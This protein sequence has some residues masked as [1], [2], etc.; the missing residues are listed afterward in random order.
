MHDD[1]RDNTWS[2]SRGTV[3]DLVQIAGRESLDYTGFDAVTLCTPSG[4]HPEQGVLAAQAGF[5]VVT[6]KPMGIALEPVD[7]MIRACDE[8]GVR[9]FTVL[10]NRLNP[11]VAL[12]LLTIGIYGLFVEFTS[13]GFGVPGVAGAIALLLGLYALHLLPV[14]WVGVGLLLFGAALMIAEVFMPS[15]GVLGVGGIVAFVAG[16]LLLF[17]RDIPG[18]GVPLALIFGLAA[19]SAAVVLL[20]G[21][22]ALRAPS[23]GPP[24]SSPSPLCGGVTSTT[25]RESTC[26]TWSGSM[27]IV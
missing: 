13:P 17:D 5:H 10:Q 16:A 11:T 21:G 27:F 7:R 26:S 9:L 12:L 23:P 14:N 8:H 4:M 2:V 1:G 22:M 20:G 19:S 25:T 3:G 24:S 18:F 15:F 6:E